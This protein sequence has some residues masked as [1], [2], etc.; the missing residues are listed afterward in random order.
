[1]KLIGCTVVDFGDWTEVKDPLA[2][3]LEPFK[4]M[5]SSTYS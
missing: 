2:K 4:Y 1:M 5:K 3:V